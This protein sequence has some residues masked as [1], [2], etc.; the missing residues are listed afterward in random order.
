MSMLSDLELRSHAERSG[1]D[2]AVLPLTLG[3]SSRARPSFATCA[4]LRAYDH[5]VDAVREAQ[6]ITTLRVHGCAVL[7]SRAAEQA[8]DLDVEE[9]HFK[10]AAEAAA[11]ARGVADGDRLG[12][13]LV[14]SL[15]SADMQSDPDQGI[16]A[17]EDDAMDAA[18]VAQFEQSERAR[19]TRPWRG[20]FQ[21]DSPEY[22]RW[23]EYGG[24]TRPRPLDRDELVAYL[25]GERG[26]DQESA[27]VSVDFY[28]HARADD[29]ALWATLEQQ[30]A[31]RE[32][33]SVCDAATPSM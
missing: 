30:K 33:A 1:I 28:S 26:Y 11:F 16:G 18:E 22:Y 13:P 17:I 10:T 8:S 20:L 23:Y 21:E 9:I 32:A 7:L 12:K 5:G 29:K 15:T 19:M 3:P 2:A 31:D 25:V 24:A 14:V 4:E 27:I 6:S